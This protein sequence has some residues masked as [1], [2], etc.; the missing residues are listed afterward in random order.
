MNTV[1]IIGIFLSFFLQFLLLAKKDKSVADKILAVWMFIFGVHLFSYY[2][3]SLGYWEVYPHL[4][5]ITNPFPLLHGPMLYLYVLFSLRSDR[6]FTRI[7][8][9]HFA[10][11][12][13][14]YVYL[15]RFYLFYTTEQKAMIDRGEL[16]DYSGFMTLSLIA[17]FVS[18]F[19]YTII[20]YRL[21]GRHQSMINENFAFRESINLN[22][23]R[24]FIW[25]IG[26]IFGG[27]ITVEILR[28]GLGVDFGFNAD[29]ILYSLII[30]FILFLGFFGIRH[31][32]V[33]TGGYVNEERIVESRTAG[34][35]ARSGLKEE[36]ALKY[37]R[38]L[39]ELMK[40][41]K[42]YLEPKLTLSTLAG[43]LDI[44]PNHLSQVINQYEGK[45]FFDFVNSYRVEEFMQRVADPANRNFS[46][47]AIAFDSGFNSKSSF[48]EVFKKIT[49]KT[50][51]KYMA[52]VREEFE[53]GNREL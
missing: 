36:D 3:Y 53:Q 27:A 42:P 23:L 31:Q 25:G 26:I 33:F 12:V 39:T 19:T 32:D 15:S 20:S 37:H 45:N 35:Y 24:Y 51:S 29:L 22:W 47:L 41:E 48:N 14:S 16:D 49:G 17:F 21:L 5:G 34:E 1:F 2:I 40:S 6:R 13:L 38:R 44:S 8:M 4:V 46:I 10:P 9:L 18:G 30:L 28:D 50:P 11:F 43:E 52:G 7:D